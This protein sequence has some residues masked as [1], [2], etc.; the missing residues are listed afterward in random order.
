MAGAAW[1]TPFP[2]PPTVAVH[3]D[4]NMLGNYHDREADEEECLSSGEDF[5]EF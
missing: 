2:R 4:R 3:Y 5:R 1:N